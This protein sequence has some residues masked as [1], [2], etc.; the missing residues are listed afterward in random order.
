MRLI[1]DA[2]D[3]EQEHALTELYR[4]AA[5]A[6]Y[7]HHPRYARFVPSEAGVRRTVVGERD[8][9]PRAYGNVVER[10]RLLARLRSGP[11]FAE[12]EDAADF[13]VSLVDLYRRRRFLR[14]EV[15]LHE[16]AGRRGESIAYRVARECRF[17]AEVKETKVTAVIPLTG[18]ADDWSD[19]RLSSKHR[20]SVR[21]ARRLGLFTELMTTSD[22]SQ[23][24][25]Q[26]V[27]MYRARGLPV[28]PRS[29]R[30]ILAG[31]YSFVQ[32]T[33]DGI[34]LKVCADDGTML[35]GVLIV[36]EAERA[37]YALGATDPQ[38]RDAPIL[39]LAILESI[40]WA[41]K[42][43][44]TLFDL[45]GYGFLADPDSQIGKISRFKDG[46]GPEPLFFTRTMQF[47]LSPAG[48]RLFDIVRSA[49]SRRR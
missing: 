13:I 49:R 5:W 47:A 11:V 38:R 6:S 1:V 28:D 19:T 9:L 46:F 41:S 23:F 32:E 7:Q 26:Y 12:P 15:Q 48:G 36:R 40:A 18:C 30:A 35:G 2:T 14:L 10:G 37:V 21:K 31:H 42:A 17:T 4:R 45:N 22:V 29:A 34:A 3:V 44:C 33:G 16:P 20:W 27:S 39:H 24:S 8:G 43:G 25:D